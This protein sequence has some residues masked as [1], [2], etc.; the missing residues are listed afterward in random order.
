MRKLTLLLAA[1]VAA[2]TSLGWSAA[3]AQQSDEAL[4]ATFE[5]VAK[6]AQEAVDT[7][8]FK[9]KPPYHIGVSA[10]YLSNSWI[11]FLNQY[12]KYEASLHPEFAD[13][14][15]T[16]AAFNPAK[17]ASDVEDL[18]SKGIDVLLFWPVD[19]KAMMPALEKVAA[20]GIPTV[21]IG[22]NFIDSAAVTSNAYVDQWKQ[23]TQ[24]ATHL[25]ESLKDKGTIFAMLP[26]AGSSAAVT[27]LAALN[28]VVK[29]H[30]DIKLAS[31][32]YGDWN[33]AKAKQLTENMLQRFPHIDGVFSP[34][35]QMSAGVLEAFDEAGRMGEVTMSPGDE[36]NG[37]VKW[38]A[39]TD[40]WGSVTSGLAVGRAAV[41]QA[42]A[43]LQGEKVTRAR[44]VTTEYLTP[45]DAAKLY[46]P[47]RPDDWW[48]SSL[49]EKFLPK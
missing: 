38:I 42:L 4:K 18:L 25:A 22:Y 15:V 5:R 45:K 11:L 12:V 27:Q 10:G 41:I 9:K 37:W 20:K 2:M 40:K 8:R 48:P 32:Q 6:L 49:P 31:V 14:V 13:V 36:Y 28:D 46:D 7:T 34:A 33:R 43:I 26:I 47:K 16:D 30:P 1:A 17:Q 29:T 24:V 23:S 44:V 3:R 35:G 21:N 19:E 39:K